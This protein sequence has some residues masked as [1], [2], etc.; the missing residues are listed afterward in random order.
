MADSSENE[1]VELPD[2][3]APSGPS[4]FTAENGVEVTDNG[5]GT[6]TDSFGDPVNAAGQAIDKD[7]N[8]I[9]FGGKVDAFNDQTPPQEVPQNQGAP[10]KDASNNGASGGSIPTPKLP[11]LPKDLGVSNKEFNF[12]FG[13]TTP[14]AAQVAEYIEALKTIDSSNWNKVGSAQYPDI[15]PNGYNWTQAIELMKNYRYFKDGKEE[16]GYAWV[17]SENEVWAKWCENAWKDDA[18]IAN[19]ITQIWGPN[20]G[21]DDTQLPPKAQHHIGADIVNSPKWNSYSRADFR[22]CGR[23]DLYYNRVTYFGFIET[24]L[25]RWFGAAA[26]AGVKQGGKT[27]QQYQDAIDAAQK[28]L[29]SASTVAGKL[30]GLEALQ[31]AYLDVGNEKMALS[32]Q[33]QIETIQKS[34]APTPKVVATGIGTIVVVA[35]LLYL[36][37][38]Q[39]KG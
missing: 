5:D 37:A 7:G 14:S 24:W 33:E 30:A 10:N 17:A 25:T 21:L 38:T 19:F 32:I 28:N 35:V 12:H 6:Y 36:A 18:S 11:K 20:E 26:T 3:P 22:E 27:A 4:Y 23:A 9:A 2:D 1:N 15:Q 13:A 39:V 34:L 31:N 8:V 29:N 16:G